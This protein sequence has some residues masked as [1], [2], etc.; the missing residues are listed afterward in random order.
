MVG[1]VVAVAISDFPVYVVNV[2]AA[3]K[4]GLGELQQDGLMTLFFLAT[5]AV[6]LGIR[7]TFGVGLPFP[8]FQ[9]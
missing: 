7:H 1:A 4:T 9:H 5:L 3:Y 8:G 6:G 2:Y